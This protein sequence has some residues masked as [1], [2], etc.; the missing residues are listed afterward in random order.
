MPIPAN[1]H[2][3]LISFRISPWFNKSY[4]AALLLRCSVFL[5]GFCLFSGTTNSASETTVVNILTVDKAQAGFGDLVSNW[6]TALV[7]KK[8][9]PNLNINF[10]LSE[11]F[12]DKFKKIE[13]QFNEMLEVQPIDGITIF[14]VLPNE[15]GNLVSEHEFEAK[16]RAWVPDWLNLSSKNQH[17]CTLAF[18]T[19]LLNVI[20]DNIMDPFDT[21]T[22]AAGYF[23]LEGM[24]TKLEI[25]HPQQKIQRRSH[26]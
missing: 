2:T 24:Q 12:R 10:Y 1:K 6:Y 25:I 13:P 16:I 26:H 4:P 5:L 7:L 9:N 20:R 23:V 11:P 14:S 22:R 8:Q 3:P 18:T 17:I 21:R 19:P 15:T